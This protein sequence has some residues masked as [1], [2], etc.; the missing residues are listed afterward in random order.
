MENY[1][2]ILTEKLQKYQLDHPKN[3]QIWITGEEILQSNQSIIT[4]QAKF[5]Y[6]PISKAFQKQTKPVEEQ[7]RNK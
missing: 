7:G 2:M 5:T 4:D 1:K 6:S 3:W